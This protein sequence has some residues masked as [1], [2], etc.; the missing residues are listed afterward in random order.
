MYS[1]VYRNIKIR[2]KKSVLRRDVVMKKGE[3]QS[4]MK[5]IVSEQLKAEVWPFIFRQD[6]VHNFKQLKFTLHTKNQIAF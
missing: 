2:S 4:G 3:W 6:T 1:L 5:R